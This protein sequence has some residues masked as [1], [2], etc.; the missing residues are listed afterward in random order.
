MIAL[1]LSS[2][3]DVKMPGS[4]DQDPIFNFKLAK[5][6]VSVRLHYPVPNLHFITV[7]MGLCLH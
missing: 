1:I 6:D 2:R 7:S 5:H 4:M 3:Y